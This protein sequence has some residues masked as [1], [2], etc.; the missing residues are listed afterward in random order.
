MPKIPA[1]LRTWSLIAAVAIL[2][3]IV[4]LGMATAYVRISRKLA[5]YPLEQ[6]PFD[7]LVVMVAVSHSLLITA[8]LARAMR[9]RVWMQVAIAAALTFAVSMPFEWVMRAV[10]RATFP[11]VHNISQ[12]Q[13]TLAV[14]VASTVFWSAPF[15]LWAVASLTGLH[16]REAQ[17][18]ERRML[19][20]QAQARE[21]QLL[22]L[23]Y[24]VNP[25]FLFNT[26][27]TISALI[28][29]KRDRDADEMVM[30]LSGFFH[31]TLEQDPLHDT[32]LGDE[33]ALQRL[34]LE[35]ERV[36]FEDQLAI[37]VDLPDELQGALAPSLILQ[38]LVENAVKHGLRGPDNLMR[39]RL[40]ARAEGGRL[41]L[42]VA[43][44][45]RGAGSDR[46]GR[47]VG[48]ANV[49]QRLATR[50]PGAYAFE[51]GA[52]DDGGFRVQLG[53]PLRFA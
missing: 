49:E 29:E 41:L 35:I 6:I 33:I 38:P 21:A 14:I 45:G 18:R 50:F 10:A 43:D 53:F 23:R 5:M 34:Y 7:L 44:D 31:A 4:A 15:G 36:R 3:W 9:L 1:A 37:E 22:A 16:A 20:A 30:R 2:F 51:A 11:D 17:R 25:H 52:G 28:L 40:A 32:P 27:N 13:L 19:A 26:L 42:E 48:L 8:V 39:L 46:L 24:Q 47:G 12:P